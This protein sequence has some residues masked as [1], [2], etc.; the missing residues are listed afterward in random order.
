MLWSACTIYDN[1]KSF[2]TAG[3]KE[4]LKQAN[5]YS[6]DCFLQFFSTELPSKPLFVN[7]LANDSNAL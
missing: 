5:S 2:G 7:Y 1:G 3:I 6:F 4:N